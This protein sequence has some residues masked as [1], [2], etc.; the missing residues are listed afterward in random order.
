MKKQSFLLICALIGSALMMSCNQKQGAKIAQNGDSAKI[1]K[2]IYLQLYSVRD[3]INSDFKGT[4]AKVAEIGYTGIEAAG[5]AD[6]KFYG[7]EPKEFKAEIENV[8]MEVLS[9]HAGRPLAENVAQTNWEEVWKWWDE[10]IAAHKAAGMKYL[11]VPWIPTPKTLADLKSYC[12]YFNQIGEKCNAAG[13]R[14]GY[15]NHNFEFIEIEGQTM[16]DYMLNNTD[17]SKV[18]FQMDVY[19]TVRGG[20]SPVEYFKKYPGRFE[21]L[22]I[23]D[24]KELGQSGMV[25]FDAIFNN[26]DK[27]GAKY[28]IVEVEKYDY[29]PFESIK[30]SYDY[31]INSPFVKADYSRNAQ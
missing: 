3:D 11:V 8:G 28:I 23:K 2:K 29:S 22:H 5:Y 15:H 9:S 26:I 25:G 30:M 27:A 19:W 18:F 31:L 1:D 17:P 7:L 12:D 6:G 20:K 10:A 13:L 4:I 24:E 21:L 16:Y 14:F